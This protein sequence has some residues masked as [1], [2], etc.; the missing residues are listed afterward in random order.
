MAAI[1]AADYPLASLAR[2]SN[3]HRSRRSVRR[4]DADEGLT[5][6]AV[7]GI[8][9]REKE[10]GAYTYDVQ[11]RRGCVKKKQTKFEMSHQA[12]GIN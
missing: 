9:N 12:F 8:S 4:T 10:E 11:F 5:I 1:G 7:I 2:W 6:G 3:T